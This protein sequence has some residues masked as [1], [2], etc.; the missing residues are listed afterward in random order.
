MTALTS[1]G[2]SAHQVSEPEVSLITFDVTADQFAL[3][4]MGISQILKY[5][6]STEVPRAPDFVEGIILLRNQVIPVIDLRKRLFQTTDEEKRE[7]RVLVI[8][9]SGITVGLKVDKV[10]KIVPVR[11]SDILPAPPIVQGSDAKY[12]KG[13]VRIDSAVVLLLDIDRILT[14]AEKE[15][16]GQTAKLAR[17]AG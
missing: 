7:K 6:G 15:L 10:R 11:V 5:E 8:R 3:D 2:A 16:L 17:A 4:I 12:F 1:L 9:V 14:V 13:V